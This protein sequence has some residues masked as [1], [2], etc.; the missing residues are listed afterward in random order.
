[1]AAA[2]NE[3]IP[4][5]IATSLRISI[6]ASRTYRQQCIRLQSTQAPAMK[7]THNVAESIHHIIPHTPPHA[8]Q[9]PPY[10]QP[11]FPPFSPGRPLSSALAPLV[12]ERRVGFENHLGL[13]SDMHFL[14]LPVTRNLVVAYSGSCILWD[15]SERGLTASVALTIVQSGDGITYRLER[16]NR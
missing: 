10:L 1:M 15:I 8:Y 5:P 4:G 16:S 2:L 7:I 9:H 12:Q 11:R 3:T 6:T 14:G 13:R